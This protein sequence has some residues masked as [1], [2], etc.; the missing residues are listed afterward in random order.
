MTKKELISEVA[1]ET[2]LSK[3]DAAAAVDA[4]FEIIS[5]EMVK[6][7]KVQILGFG[8]FE[9]TERAERVGKNPSTKEEMIIPACYA[10]K[11][12]PSKVL[13]DAVNV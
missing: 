5:K 12:K 6:K 4:T 2:S 1:Q 8:N 13:K 3:K 10:P 9:V 7:G 11:F